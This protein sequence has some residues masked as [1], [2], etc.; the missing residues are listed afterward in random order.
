M[1]I[2]CRPSDTSKS[3]IVEWIG[4]LQITPKCV[5]SVIKE[6]SFHTFADANGFAMGLQKRGVFVYP[7]RE[8]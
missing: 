8:I 1:I 3:Y 6:K 5:S 4:T 7:I 2:Q